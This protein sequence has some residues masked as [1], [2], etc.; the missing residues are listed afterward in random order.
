MVAP[1][2][3]K[4]HSRT[5]ETSGIAHGG[6]GPGAGGFRIAF[7]GDAPD[8]SFLPG[9]RR[10][11]DG[12]LEAVLHGLAR[13][14]ELIREALPIEPVTR[15]W[16]RVEV[17]LGRGT[18]TQ[19]EALPLGDGVIRLTL[20]EDAPLAEVEQIARHEALHLLLSKGLHAGTRWN[21]PELAFADWIVR[22]LES[23]LDP[24][25]PRFHAPLPRLFDPLPRS[26]EEVRGRLS[27]RGAAGRRWFG[28]PLLAALEKIAAGGGDPAWIEQR[29]L[30]LV[31]AAL[32]T[33]FIEATGRL[34]LEDGEALRP[35]VLDDWLLEFE[36]HARG[37]AN[38][39][40][41]T[42]NL[43]HLSDAGWSRDPLVRLS[44]AAQILSAGDHHAFDERSAAADPVVW[45]NGGRIRLPLLPSRSGR[46]PP[47]L[48][49]F[50]AVLRG[51]GGES[52]ARALSAVE[53]AGAGDA[54]GFE[55]RVL[56]PRILAR[57]L[58]AFSPEEV[59]RSPVARVQL[60][61]MGA[62][63]A[64]EW[65]DAA[66]SLREVLG[67]F[68]A[69]VPEI[70]PARPAATL[71]DGERPEAAILLV[72]GGA[73][74]PANLV[75]ARRVAA[76]VPIRGALFR[77]LRGGDAYERAPDL[78]TPLDPRYREEG[79]ES[80]AA[81]LG[82]LPLAADAATAAGRLTT[83]LS[84]LLSLMAFGVLECH[85]SY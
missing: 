52:A 32:G 61:D 24:A 4:M 3:F 82:D 18:L 54:C 40:G 62:A 39:P 1:K 69:W 72:H 74:E 63:A 7:D 23:G 81:G 31:E 73:L 78:E 5:Q 58:P 15:A 22:A 70:A 33:H 84:H 42:G 65:Q 19:G 85:Y 20:G 47:P 12:L 59:E 41:G 46:R 45:K 2:S 13:A 71:F 64:G 49:T 76:L 21:D 30:W 34:G 10:L 16:I 11:Q 75:A 48:Q 8:V 14:P 6:P 79:W 25:L 35:L 55:A 67:A 28:D 83:P 36:R 51:L 77:D 57:L 80:G 43:W 37:V 38:A 60:V 26:R 68:A 27:D 50:R 17:T 53:E 56:W 66:R 29:Q 44:A 9:P